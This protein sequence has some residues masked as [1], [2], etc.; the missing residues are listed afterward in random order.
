MARVKILQ[1][2]TGLLNAHPWPAAG[3][4]CDLPDAVAEA[5][6][7]TGWVE[8]L[9]GEKPK[10]ARKPAAEKRPAAKGDTEDR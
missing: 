8:V 6:A 5:M 10:R 3:E 9:A 1:Q 2:P 4:E 7:A